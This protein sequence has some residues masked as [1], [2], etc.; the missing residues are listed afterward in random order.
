MQWAN[1]DVVVIV[2]RD[3]QV[4]AM[5]AVE[6]ANFYLGRTRVFKPEGNALILE[7]PRDCTL[8]E[9]FFRRLNGMP[10]K[11]LNAYWA[12]LEFS[13][14]VQPP[15]ALDDSRAV[16]DAVRKNRNAIGYIDAALVD[17]SVRVVLTLKD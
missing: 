15:R 14:E 7:Q 13:G 11:Q 1:A 3:N 4:S 8:R 16:L 9:E 6:V 5:T 2:N 12:R 17:S 10:I